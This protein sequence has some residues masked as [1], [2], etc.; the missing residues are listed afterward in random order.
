MAKHNQESLMI[1][2]TF[3]LGVHQACVVHALSPHS[4][5]QM[6]RV[7]THGQRIS[8]E[9]K[10]IG[11][12]KFLEAVSLVAICALSERWAQRWLDVI[13]RSLQRSYR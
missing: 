10:A 9:H 3:A 5:A 6:V 4:P 8:I 12:R 2:M 13:K 7:T 11:M 1:L